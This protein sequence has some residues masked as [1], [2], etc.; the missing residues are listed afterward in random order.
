M[1]HWTG[2]PKFLKPPIFNW[3]TP[4]KYYAQKERKKKTIKNFLRFKKLF[5]KKKTEKMPNFLN[6]PF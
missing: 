6:R 4:Q 5:K 2:E 3:I 1:C